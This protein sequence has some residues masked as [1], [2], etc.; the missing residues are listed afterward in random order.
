MKVTV[1]LTATAAGIASLISAADSGLRYSPDDLGALNWMVRLGL[2]GAALL[3]V[4]AVM[5]LAAIVREVRR[6]IARSGLTPVQ[7]AFA[8]AA[9]LGVV[10]YEWSKRNA[11]WSA[12]LTESVMGP[13]REALWPSQD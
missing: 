4:P 6:G 8:E 11:A 9:V 10:H 5:I 12:D 13:E 7:A 3:A 1:G 2:L